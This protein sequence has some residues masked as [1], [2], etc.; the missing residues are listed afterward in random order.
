MYRDGY[1]DLV[2]SFSA[3]EHIPDSER[4]L[5]EALGVAAPGADLYRLQSPLDV[6]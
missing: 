1:F 4:A 3:F 5:G 2:V 6:R